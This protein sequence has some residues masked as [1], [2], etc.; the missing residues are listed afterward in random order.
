MC[1]IA[2]AVWWHPD[3]AIDATVLR[4]MTDT[5]RHRGPDAEGQALSGAGTDSSAGVA[6]GHRRLS[7]IDVAGSAQPM[8]NEDGTVSLIFNGEIYNYR[9]LREGLTANHQFRTTGDTEVIIHL[10]EEYG[11]D[12]VEHLRGMFALAIWDSR[13]QRLVLA[14]VG[15]RMAL[16][17]RATSRPLTLTL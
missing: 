16:R 13:R 15:L 12:F 17:F 7:I 6:L 10:Y 9:E 14:V 1:G 11:L 3:S 8:S 2:G 5:I 4:R